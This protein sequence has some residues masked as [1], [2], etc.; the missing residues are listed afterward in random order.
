M[1][2]NWAEASRLTTSFRPDGDEDS[3]VGDWEDNLHYGPDSQDYGKQSH[4]R[5]KLDFDCKMNDPPATPKTKKHKR[6][7]STPKKEDVVEESPRKR[8][9]TEPTED[10]N[11]LTMLHEDDQARRFVIITGFQEESI[12]HIVAEVRRCHQY[13]INKLKYFKVLKPNGRWCPRKIQNSFTMPASKKHP[14][15]S[16]F[17]IP[18]NNQFLK[19][20]FDDPYYARQAQQAFDKALFAWN[21]SPLSAYLWTEAAADHFNAAGIFTT[22]G[23]F[24]TP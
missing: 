17:H 13:C 22:A 14:I 23:A 15:I 1:D 4:H 19:L 5:T 6:T 10:R 12:G 11:R 3:W 20:E 21:G 16:F 8:I 7:R 24:N 18:S 2:Y 9:K